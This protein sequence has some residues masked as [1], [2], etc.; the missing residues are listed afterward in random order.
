MVTTPHRPDIGTYRKIRLKPN[1]KGYYEIWWTDAAAGYATK[2]ESCR[3]K[4]LAQ[5]ETYLAAFCADARAQTAVTT[6]PRAPT[7]EELCQGWLLFVEAQGKAKVG[8]YV[9]TAVRRELGH[10]T[11]DQ[12]DG[13]VLQDYARLRG[14]SQ[15]TIRRELG[16]LR[17]VLIWAADTRQIDRNDVPTFKRVI[18]PAGPPR[19][20]FLDETQE[21]QFWAAAMSWGEARRWVRRQDRE[22]SY[23]VML[24]VALG[25]ETA[26]RRGAILELTWDR[27][28]LGRGTIDYRIPKGRLT[29]KR[30]VQGLPI[31]DRL[32]PV[33]KEAWLRAPKDAA[34]H[35]QGRV[36]GCNYIGPAFARFA[37]EAG[38]GWVTPHV[39]RHTWG[40]LKAMKGVPLYDIAQ[41]MGD[42]MATIEA[43]YLH[44]SPDHLRRAVNA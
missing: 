43:N 18:P 37:R 26:A 30:R 20:R 2:R 9:L 34:G 41:V 3:T 21:Q 11:A 27:V 4:D 42:T 36:I 31:S 6:A 44:L 8:R 14:R 15:G 28:D 16:G 35:A 1:A 24:F 7:V 5:A 39:L 25:L 13:L 40:S 12:L 32:M 17:T 33:L 29:K 19:S 22:S 10:Y 23:R 38:L